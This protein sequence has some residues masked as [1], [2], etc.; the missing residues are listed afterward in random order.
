M[1]SSAVR[2]N[3]IKQNSNSCI[4][5][6]INVFLLNSENYRL[7]QDDAVTETNLICEKIAPDTGSGAISKEN[8][9]LITKLFYLLS[10]HKS[11]LRMGYPYV[12]A[13]FLRSKSDIVK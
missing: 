13:H 11:M 5:T 3:H 4:W 10:L 2:M 6:E 7:H 9:N 1:N 8:I 12:P